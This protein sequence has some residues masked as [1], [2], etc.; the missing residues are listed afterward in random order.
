MK[1]FMCDNMYGSLAFAWWVEH[2][3]IG[4]EMTVLF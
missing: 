1:R 2:K 4:S 3:T